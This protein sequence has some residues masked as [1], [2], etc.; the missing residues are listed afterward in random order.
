M[1]EAIY[2]SRRTDDEEGDAVTLELRGCDGYGSGAYGAS[3]GDRTHNGIDFQAPCG[4]AILSPVD[5][6]VTRLGYPYSDD[7][8]YR[9]V[10]ILTRAGLKHRIFYIDPIVQLGDKIAAGDPIGRVQDVAGR[11]DRHL[12]KNHIHYELKTGN[13]KYLNP[14][15]LI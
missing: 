10:E 1:I 4:A 14:E 9:Y 8:S 11:Y 6:T 7:L 5:G 12:M 13:G 2:P 3:R 15:T